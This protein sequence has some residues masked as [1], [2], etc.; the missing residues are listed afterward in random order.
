[1][2]IPGA[3]KASGNL[4]RWS[5]RDD[6]IP[7]LEQIFAEH[8]DNVCGDFDMTAQ[9]IADSLG[10][11]FT[12]IYGWIIE[13][14]FTTK[15]DEGHNVIDDFLK[16]RGWRE[17]VPAKR[18]LRALRDSAFSFYEVLDV[19][20]G[21]SIT[22]RDLISGG[23]GVC[24]NEISGS[25]S[26]HRWDRLAARIVT[27]NDRIYFTGSLLP[28][29][30]EAANELLDTIDDAAKALKKDLLRAAK[31][32]GEKADPKAAD[33]KKFILETNPQLISRIWLTE[34]LERMA[35][36]RPEFRNTDGHDLAFSE[37]RFPIKGAPA[38]IA[39][40]LDE[41][42]AFEADDPG[43][44]SWTWHGKKSS[45]KP[46]F[47]EDALTIVTDDGSGTPVLGGIEIKDDMV[48]LNANSR[49]RAELGRDIVFSRL[50]GLLGPPLMSLQ[51]TEQLLDDHDG[52]A[53]GQDEIPPEIAEQAI[54]DYLDD[55]YVKSLKEPLPYLDGKTPLQAVKTKKGREKVVAWLKRLENTEARRAA[56]QGQ[57][58]Y[59]SRWMWKDLKVE[60]L[61]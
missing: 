24:V 55:F 34:T 15:F 28:F 38:E 11:A 16:R 56:G 12:M 39:T 44:W 49:E 29:N 48:V 3:D 30:H 60:N 9:E 2:R 41:I 40:A 10:D 5:T 21:H 31:D 17:K 58:P 57:Q 37:V 47:H 25:Q 53:P 52:D 36:P 26:V 19:D 35:A 27:V 59:D 51:A 42:E 4:I 43:R 7:M 1:M 46:K 23:D 18:Y 20:P 32:A 8:F 50:E 61:R 33:L 45:A 54:H 13:D 6:W 22:V 14:F